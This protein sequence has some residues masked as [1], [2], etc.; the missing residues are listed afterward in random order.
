M[1]ENTG[2]G[3]PVAVYQG[4]TWPECPEWG[5]PLRPHCGTPLCS[6]RCT[7]VVVHLFWEIP[8]VNHWPVVYTGGGVPL[9]ENTASV[10][11]MAV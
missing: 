11:S 6:Q 9:A 7:R 8:I 4:L 10:A 3:V 2:S 5:L 1:A